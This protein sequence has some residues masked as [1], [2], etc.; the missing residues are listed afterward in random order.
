MRIF[1]RSATF[2]NANDFLRLMLIGITTPGNNTLPRSNSSGKSSGMESS[3]SRND[4][5]DLVT[6]GI[7][8]ARLAIL[9]K[10]SESS[11]S[12]SISIV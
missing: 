12:I 3:F 11:L 10:P 8:S 2:T 5:S 9:S 7:I 6:K 4:S 1:F